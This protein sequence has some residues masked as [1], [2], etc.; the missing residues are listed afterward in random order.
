MATTGATLYAAGRP[1]HVK[2]LKVTTTRKTKVLGK[3]E[4]GSAMTS[5]SWANGS[6]MACFPAT[7]NQNFEGHHVLYAVE[8]PAQSEL[9][10]K[11]N[12]TSSKTDL[13]VYG[14][15]IGT[16]N[17]SVPPSL[18]SA[19]TCEA[20][21]DKVNDSNPG[22]TESVKVTST[23]NPYN[24]VVGVAGA[25]GVAAGEFTLSLSLTSR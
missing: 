2:A 24:V 17:Y 25:K 1:G 19:V 18:T 23:T 3:L 16:T 12:P 21:Y 10:I 20:G 14:I 8:M 7:E 6:S 15:R 4:S 5:L 9:E 13:S 11:A 22:V